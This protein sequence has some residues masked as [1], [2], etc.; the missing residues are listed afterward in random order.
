VWS[1]VDAAHSI[2]Q[3]V[4]IDLGKVQPDLWVSVSGGVGRSVCLVD[5]FPHRTVIQCLKKLSECFVLLDCFVNNSINFEAP[6]HIF[7]MVYSD[8]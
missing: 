7:P 6:F 1:V 4:G 2:G 5:V 8:F 3:E